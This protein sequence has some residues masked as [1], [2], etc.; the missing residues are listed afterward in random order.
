[1]GLRDFAQKLFSGLNGQ[2]AR[3]GGRLDDVEI[4]D[5]GIELSPD[6]TMDYYWFELVER[7]AGGEWTGFRA[8]KLSELT[9]I[10]QEARASKSLIQKTASLAR[11]LWAAGVELIT[12]SF[13]IFDPPIGI[14]QC[15]GVGT[16]AATKEAAAQLAQEGHAALVANFAAQF[17]QSRLQPLSIDRARFLYNARAKMPHVTTLIGQPDPREGARGGA[18]EEGRSKGPELFTEQQNELLFRAMARAQEEFLFINIATPVARGDL[19]RMEMALGNLTSP[20]AS[21]Q[22]G[23]SSIGFG[24]SLPVMLSVAQGIS[25]GQAYGTSQNQGVSD[26]VGVARGVAH[27]DGTASGSSWSHAVGAAHSVGVA[28]TDSV[29]HTTGTSHGVAVTHGT[30]ES[31]GTAVTDGTASTHGV[32]SSSSSSISS[33]V[34]NSQSTSNG[35][36]VGGNVSGQLQPEV[37]ATQVGNIGGG[38]NAGLN[39]S[40]S[41]G[42]TLSSGMATTTGTSVMDSTT[43][44]H[45]TTTSHSTGVSDA[46]S[47]SDGNMDSFSYGHATTHSQADTASVSD[48]V[49]GSFTRSQ[50]DSVSQSTS[51][52]HGVSQGQGL[53]LARTLGSM[54]SMGL[55]AGVAPSAS[56]SKSFQWKDENAVALA[57]LLE[58]Q[59]HILA[60]AVEEGGF[61]SD[62]YFLTRN[63]HG[64]RTAEAA[65]VQA[66]GGSQRVVTHI[67]PRRPES[68]AEAAHLRRHAQCFSPS[69]LTETLG[70]ING[71]AFATLVTPTQQ[72]AYTAPGLFEEGVALTMQER[73]PPFAFQPDLPGDVVLGHLYSTE[74]GEQTSAQLR[75]SEDRHFHTV[76][77]ADTGFGKTVA[78]ERLAVEVVNTWHHRA[79]VLDFGAGW[80]KLLNSSIPAGRLDIYQLYPG[81]QR[82]LRWNFLQIGRRIHPEQQFR[83]TA[84]LMCAAGRMGPRQFG[85]LQEALNLL[86]LDAGVLEYAPGGVVVVAAVDAKWM[87]VQPDEVEIVKRGRREVG[88]DPDSPPVRP[89]QRLETLAAFE[90]QAL[91]VYRSRTVSVAALYN[92]LRER[93][94][95]LS[96]RSP[97]VSTLEGLL[98]RLEPLAIG[99]MARMYG[100]G[101]ETTGVEDLGLLGPEPNLAERWGLCILEGGAQMDEYA[102]TTVLSLAAWHLYHDAVV[103]RQETIGG[104]NRPL[105]IFWEEA[106]KILGGAAAESDTSTSSSAGAQQLWLSMWRDG[107][108]YSIFQHAMV[109]TLQEL[110]TGILS[111]SNNA[112]FGQM[113]DLKDRD[114]AM[115]HLARSE[116]GFTDEEYKR[117]LS[118]MPRELA[119][120]KFGYAAD[121]AQLEPM[122]VRPLMVRCKEP[123]NMEILRRFGSGR[124]PAHA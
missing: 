51:A 42:T 4:L 84:Q 45:A 58:E 15:Y 94:K 86:Y 7:G 97:D 82:P 106:N 43:T 121:V 96:D 1:M 60:E 22:Q 20:I 17:P 92:K 54:Q 37:A 113:K 44:S 91:R 65:A 25:A 117:F 73:T 99:E 23:S 55:G 80:R 124:R 39:G 40:S 115:G 14:V 59:L 116:K 98:L 102:K 6:H 67:Q 36:T 49:G 46:V 11:G 10:P 104:F 56:V 48:S 68:P 100:G 50:S 2:P 71:Y 70:W 110:P 32:G 79:V 9:Y 47:K 105:D 83:A 16:R 118:R 76:F 85:F 90:V 31:S 78:A 3:F 34:A 112:F 109:Q 81:A 87:F 75:L 108:K 89:G 120:V 19:I 53:S 88:L 57:E 107:R 74:R 12:L 13:G 63:E 52:A 122:L 18:Q 29:T 64:R 114:L 24:V 5:A 103:R 38:F 95:L 27:T 93:K 35:W 41:E 111:S 26:S 33:G 77:A 101:E 21:R 62:S 119:I 72:A 30:S 8:V 61:Y 28:E 69:T 123:T 66:F